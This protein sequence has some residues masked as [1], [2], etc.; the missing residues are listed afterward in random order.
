MSRGSLGIIRTNLLADIAAEDMGAD[1]RTQVR[2]DRSFEFDRQVGDA[3][4][5]IK[6]IRAD[7]GPCG[8][9]L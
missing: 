9:G 7:E 4:A 2:W 1:K 3:A 5:G 6:H 8:A